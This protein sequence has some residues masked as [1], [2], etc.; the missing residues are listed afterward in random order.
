MSSEKKRKQN[1]KR[2]DVQEKQEKIKKLE[3][4]RKILLFSRIRHQK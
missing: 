1:T 3:E 4:N 2:Q